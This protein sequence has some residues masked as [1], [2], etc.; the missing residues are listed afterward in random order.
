MINKFRNIMTA[1][2]I[3]TVGQISLV[4]MGFNNESRYS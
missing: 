3:L 2:K 4:K 1:Y